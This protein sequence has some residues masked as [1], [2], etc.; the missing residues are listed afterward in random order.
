MAGSGLLP[1]CSSG[2][3]QRVFP[4]GRESAQICEAQNCKPRRAWPGWLSATRLVFVPA[5]SEH[6]RAS[7][8]YG[9]LRFF[10][11]TI[12]RTKPVWKRT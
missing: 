7:A 11:A 5:N 3:G 4:E 2:E 10:E 6:I 12:P 8:L 9:H 1:G